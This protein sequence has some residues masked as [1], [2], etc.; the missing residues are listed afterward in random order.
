MNS[1]I[2]LELIQYSTEIFACKY[3]FYEC[4]YV[5]EKVEAKTP[6][7]IRLRMGNK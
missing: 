7:P 4:I 6:D 2:F 5:P 3:C 1:Q